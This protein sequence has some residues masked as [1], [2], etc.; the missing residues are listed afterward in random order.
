MK[1]ARI[2]GNIVLMAVLAAVLTLAGCGGGGGD[3]GG[4]PPAAGTLV[5]GSITQNTTWLAADSPYII[6]GVVDVGAPGGALLT[7]APGVVVKFESD[8]CLRFAFNGNPGGLY[9]VGSADQHITFTSASA[10]PAAGDWQCLQFLNETMAGTR[11][12]YCDLSYAGADPGNGYDG[13]A[14][15]V[16]GGGPTGPALDIRDSAI[17]HSSGFGL[18]L[19]AGASFSAGASALT[20]ADCAG[21][22]IGIGLRQ[23]STIPAGTYTPANGRGFRLYGN[24]LDS[25]STWKNLAGTD[26]TT[27]AYYPETDIY[28]T[29][30]V[31]TLEA[32]VHINMAMG[33]SL[34]V[35]FSCDSGKL[36]ANGTSAAPIIIRSAAAAPANNDWGA[37]KIYEPGCASELSYVYL[38]DGGIIDGYTDDGGNPRQG[39]IAVLRDT[40]GPGPAISHCAL[41]NYFDYAILTC[42]CTSDYRAE[43]TFSNAAKTQI[44][45]S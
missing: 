42:N 14:I 45:L 18:V 40:S 41:E 32:G 10:A 8:A 13:A 6:R 33:T 23:A 25:D 38:R 11:L 24:W 2:S 37:L 4:N 9:A 16:L 1:P 3:G 22:P 15:Q 44:D 30:A 12:A 27:V 28:V 20:I 7:I 34:A 29:D 17:R 39:L 35:G 19:Q 43:N 36:I 21:H 31:L 5:A 26:G